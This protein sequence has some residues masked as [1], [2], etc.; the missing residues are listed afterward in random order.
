M[1]QNQD[2]P[3]C[4]LLF[5]FLSNLFRTQTEEEGENL[6]MLDYPDIG[7]DL[8]MAVSTAGRDVR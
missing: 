7:G 4:D 6:Y 3:L 8:A 1:D 5:F 2:G